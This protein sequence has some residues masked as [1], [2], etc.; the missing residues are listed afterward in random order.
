MRFA[1]VATAVG[2]EKVAPPRL[3]QTDHPAPSL[4]VR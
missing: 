3:L 1:L 2:A 4:K